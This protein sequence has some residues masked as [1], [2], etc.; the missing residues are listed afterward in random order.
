MGKKVEQIR[1]ITN[2]PPASWVDDGRGGSVNPSY[3][4]WGTAAA[5]GAKVVET[6]Q[7]R[8]EARKGAEKACQEMCFKCHKP[9]GLIEYH[10]IQSKADDPPRKIHVPCTKA[11]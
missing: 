11:L 1:H 5:P 2:Q 10:V 8:A 4:G 6:V 9:I 7:T 3:V